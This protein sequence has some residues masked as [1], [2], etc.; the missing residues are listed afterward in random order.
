MKEVVRKYTEHEK[1]LDESK[2]L[3]KEL[4]EKR[5]LLGNEILNY[6]KSQDN[7]RVLK[8]E[9]GTFKVSE[10]KKRQR[11]CSEYVEKMAQKYIPIQNQD[12]MPFLNAVFE[13]RPVLETTDHLRLVKERKKQ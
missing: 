13:E 5:D 12:L 1:D 3:I 8:T 10:S 2:R 6:M 11:V 9:F 4:K 7:A